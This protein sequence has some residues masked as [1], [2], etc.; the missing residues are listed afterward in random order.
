[1]RQARTR[2]VCRCAECD[3]LIRVSASHKLDLLLASG[4]YRSIRICDQ[5]CRDAGYR[6]KIKIKQII[7]NSAQA[8]KEYIYPDKDKPEWITKYRD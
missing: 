1:M 5:C 7:L 8:T 4:K 3:K 6:I 2:K